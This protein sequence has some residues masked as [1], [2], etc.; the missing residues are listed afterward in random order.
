[1]YTPGPWQFEWHGDGKAPV[2]FAL[3]PVGDYHGSDVCEV[4]WT[5]NH[6]ESLTNARLI[7]AAPSMLAVMEDL[8]ESIDDP[9]RLVEVVSEAQLIIGA[10]LGVQHDS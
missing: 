8:V 9:F 2:V 3:D 4:S 1:M 6:K 5:G 10:V 7:S